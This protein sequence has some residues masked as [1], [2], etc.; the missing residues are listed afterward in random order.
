ME[1]GRIFFGAVKVLFSGALAFLLINFSSLFL[2][3][4]HQSEHGSL[5]KVHCR[6]DFLR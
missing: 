5:A 6:V 1:F 4:S 2:T 3:I